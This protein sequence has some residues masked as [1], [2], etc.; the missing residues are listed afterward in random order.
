MALEAD[1][2]LQASLRGMLLNDVEQTVYSELF[3]NC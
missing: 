1:A 3:H 2:Q